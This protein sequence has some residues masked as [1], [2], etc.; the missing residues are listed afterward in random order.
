[1]YQIF[2]IVPASSPTNCMNTTFLPHNATL[3]WVEPA[4]I[5]QNGAPVGYNLTC[6][7]IN[8][9]PVSGL[10]PTQETTITVFTV[11]D[12]MPFNNYICVLTFINVIGQGPPTLC[13]FTTAQD[14]KYN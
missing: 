5:D 11:T 13:T 10:N 12:I 7:S 1:M 8:G 2:Y 6:T 9:I 3:I 14:S 4:F